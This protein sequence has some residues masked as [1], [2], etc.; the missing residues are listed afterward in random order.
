[1]KKFIALAASAPLAVL[2]EGTT[3]TMDTTST[4]AMVE[5]AQSGLSGLLT[6]VQPFITTLV[7]AGLAIWAGFKIISLIKRAFSRAA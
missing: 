1:M 5:A 6:T 3:P 4:S 7:L 2:A